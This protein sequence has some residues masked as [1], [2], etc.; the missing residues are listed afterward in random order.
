MRHAQSADFLSATVAQRLRAITL[1]GTAFGLCSALHSSLSCTSAL[2]P[3]GLN[4]RLPLH[5]RRVVPSALERSA[6]RRNGKADQRPMLAWQSS[7][8]SSI[9]TAH[10]V[11]PTALRDRPDRPTD[12]AALRCAAE[13]CTKN[14]RAVCWHCNSR[15]LNAFEHKCVHV[16]RRVT[17]GST[18]R[19]YR[20]R[21][22]L[23]RNRFIGSMRRSASWQR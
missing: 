23:R 8:A 9:P 20:W 4:A 2:K 7:V 19:T 18:H 12:S 3:R 22:G 5:P 13:G 16:S 14:V 10:A 11:R 21:L 6:A 1:I 17:F 15:A